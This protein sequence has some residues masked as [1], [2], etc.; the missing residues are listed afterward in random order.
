MNETLNGKICVWCANK[1]REECV[2]RCREEGRYRY[3]DPEPLA[4]WEL[5][6][7]L[8]PFRDLLELPA[9]ER[10]ALIYLSAY[11]RETH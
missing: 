9:V 8:P 5:P 2:T 11:Y 6:P 10:L 1:N 3:L 4:D 7:E